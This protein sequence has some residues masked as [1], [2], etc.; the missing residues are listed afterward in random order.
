MAERVFP[1]FKALVIP[2]PG[3][4]FCF[5]HPS[6]IQICLALSVKEGRQPSRETSV[7]STEDKLMTNEKSCQSNPKQQEKR[8]PGN[9]RNML[10]SHSANDSTNKYL[11]NGLCRLL[12]ELDA[13]GSCNW[14]PPFHLMRGY[15]A[16]LQQS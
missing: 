5:Y 8:Q 1:D 10:Y 12:M 11:L 15:Q 4:I 3:F 2:Y 13:L 6:P 9:V 16:Q 7:E 14:S